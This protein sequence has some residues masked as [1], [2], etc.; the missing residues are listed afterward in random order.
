MSS[1][2]DPSKNDEEKQRQVENEFLNIDAGM[3][4]LFRM[5]LETQSQVMNQGLIA[6]EQSEGEIEE[7]EPLMRA[8]HSIKGAGRVIRL[9]PVVTL[10]HDMEDCF[11][12]IQKQPQILLSNNPI[13]KVKF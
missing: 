12:A 7:I 3:M 2:N 11:V 5:E 1:P 4:D 6:F 8:A 10:A 9:D 13:I